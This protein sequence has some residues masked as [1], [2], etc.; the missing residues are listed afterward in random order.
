MNMISA[1][2]YT[3]LL[4]FL[5]FN[6]KGLGYNV[7]RKLYEDERNSLNYKQREVNSKRQ[8]RFNM[9]NFN[10]GYSTDSFNAYY[11]GQKINGASAMSFEILDNGYAKDSWSIY[12]R[13]R[14]I[15]GASAMSFE[16]IGN[17][18]A[19]DSWSVYYMGKKMNGVSPNSF[20]LNHFG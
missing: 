18:Y 9:N 14:K 20:S 3:V 15:D 19:K 10:S 12:F 6:N 11:M 8:F 4:Y 7:E 17:G 5:I 1:S 2:M 13:G 16:T